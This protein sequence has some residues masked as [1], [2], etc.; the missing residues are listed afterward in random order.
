MITSNF[1]THTFYCDGK[2]SPEELVK[3]AIDCGFT[4]LGFSSHSYCIMDKDIT[5]SP[6]K[7]KRYIE[8][9]DILKEKYQGVI[10]I[11]KGIEQDY[12]SDPVTENFDYIIGAVHY[13][14]KNGEYYAVD[15][16][17]ENSMWVINTLFGGEYD[18]FAEEYFETVCDVVD[19]TGADI[20]AHIDLV[21]KFSEK[22]GF[23]Q[24][25][26]YLAAAQQAVKTLVKY[27]KP[28]E[29]NTGAMARGAKSIPYPSP[30]ILKMIKQSGGKIA[31]SSDCHDKNYINH[32]FDIATQLALNAGFTTH[33]VITEN[34][35]KEMPIIWQ[36]TVN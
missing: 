36:K 16:S 31:F 17:K 4:S 23:G 22:N 6:E 8:E 35:I 20:I 7:L 15:L 19:K 26:R 14:K 30:E 18:A 12:Y 1:H 3:A 2:D 29:I 21:S 13:I 24:S 11:F 28:F 9:I 5:L 34:G 10:K 32:A 33:S 27:N 25:D